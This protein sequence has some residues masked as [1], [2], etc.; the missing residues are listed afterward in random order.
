MMA[1][2]ATRRGVQLSD[3]QPNSEWCIGQEWMHQDE[4]KFPVKK[5]SEITL[6]SKDLQEFNKETQALKSIDLKAPL[7]INCNVNFVVPS[8]VQARYTFSDYLI[9]PNKFRFKTVVRILA[10]VIKS[11]RKMRWMRNNKQKTRSVTAKFDQSSNGPSKDDIKNA[12][13]YFFRKATMEIKHFNKP[14]VYNKFSQEVNGILYYSGRFLPTEAI[15]IIT[16]MALSM[17][18]L[19]S[20]SFFVPIVDKHSPLAYSIIN[21]VHCYDETVKHSD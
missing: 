5:L 14:S 13:D 8:E 9:D 18:D 6:T 17:H 1:D 19:R 12:E 16:P 3:V 7:D 2:L 21:E 20:T 10:I 11:I 15:N 4:S